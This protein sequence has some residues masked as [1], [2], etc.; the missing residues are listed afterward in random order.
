MKE[1]FFHDEPYQDNQQ[2]DCSDKVSNFFHTLLQ[3]QYFNLYMESVGMFPSGLRHR[4][5]IDLN[6]KYLTLNLIHT[7][8]YMINSLTTTAG[9]ILI[10][11]FIR[12]LHIILY[13]SVF[14]EPY[15][16]LPILVSD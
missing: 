16:P 13:L 9:G 15:H 6:N 3:S 4:N 1:S 14:S 11:S 7:F 10:D 8:V 12:I 2:Q 5:T